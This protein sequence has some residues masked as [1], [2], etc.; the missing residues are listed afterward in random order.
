M[1]VDCAIYR[2]GHR[3]EGPEDLSDA[4]A[5]AR[6][7]RRV[8]LDRAARAVGEG[9]RPGHG[10]VR[11]AP[12]GRGGRPEG[13]P[14]AQAGGVRRLA[15]HGPQAGRVRAVQRHRDH[16]RGHGL[17]RRRLRG[18]R[19]PRRGLAPGRRTA[20][21][22][23]GSPNCSAKAPRPCCTRSRTPPS[24]TTWTWRPNCQTDLEELEAEVFSPDVG[25]SRNTASRIYTFKRQ[26]LEFRRATGPLAAP[27]GR[28]AGTGN[29]RRR[30]ALRRREGRSPSSVTSTTT[31]RA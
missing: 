16:R 7:S 14:A 28:L 6:A 20:A 8:R 3:T 29:V 18:D 2:D 17:P 12:A 27:L 10:G 15:V 1:I 26:I 21:G 9:V 5:A 11:A 24:T 4:L 25:G 19:P 30:G 31:S 22:W 13:A 23:S